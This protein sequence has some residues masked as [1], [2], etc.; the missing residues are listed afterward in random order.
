MTAA[1]LDTSFLLALVLADDAHHAAAVALQLQ[2]TGPLITT[3]YVLIELVDAL[4][5]E[6]LR[7]RAIATVELLRSD[8][9]VQIV[10]AT[11]EL[12]DAGLKL[13]AARPDKRWGLTDCISFTVMVRKGITD[14]LTADRHFE[15]A[16]FTALLRNTPPT[17]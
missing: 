5:A 9:M 14:A 1:F 2:I 6:A 11:S 3:E 16:G 7:P 4:A 17:S 8:P 12:M 13:F 15:Q 10:P